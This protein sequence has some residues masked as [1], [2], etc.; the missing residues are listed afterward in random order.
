M[1]SF[2]LCKVTP[3]MEVGE[4]VK[5][6]CSCGMSNIASACSCER[7]GLGGVCV[8]EISSFAFAIDCAGTSVFDYSLQ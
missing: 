6:S 5:M 1:L 8:R 7:Y 2:A 4:A 3:I